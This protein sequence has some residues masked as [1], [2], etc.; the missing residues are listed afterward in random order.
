MCA[1]DR[2]EVTGFTETPKEKEQRFP[3]TQEKIIHP[4]ILRSIL[5]DADITVDQ[6]RSLMMQAA[7]I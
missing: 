1:P 4:K 2:A 5:Q 3:F 7:S 6:F